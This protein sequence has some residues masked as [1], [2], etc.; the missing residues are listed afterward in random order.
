[1]ERNW[2]CMDTLYAENKKINELTQNSKINLSSKSVHLNTISSPYESNEKTS[3]KTVN[4]IFKH[5]FQK[6]L[7][8]LGFTD[9]HDNANIRLRRA[10]KLL[11]KCNRTLIRAENEKELLND[12]CRLTVEA[13]GYRMAWVGF[14]ERN[15]M[16]TVKPVAEFGHKKGFLENLN[17]SWD[18]SVRGQGPVGNAIRIG[19]SVVNQD[20]LHNPKFKPWRKA[21]LQCGYQSSIGLPLIVNKQV[22][23]A[24]VLYAAEP[25]AFNRKEVSL[26][27]DLANDLAFGIQTLRM[28]DEHI[29]TEKKLEFLAYHDPLTGLPN[30]RLLSDRF[31]QITARADRTKTS[32]AILYLDLDNFK[33]VNDSFGHKC[34]DQF[35]ICVAERLKNSIRKTDTLSRQGGDEFVIILN[36]ISTIDSIEKITKNIINSFEDPIQIDNHTLTTSFSIGISMYPNDGCEFD[37]LLN[38]ADTALSQSKE[39]GK[40]TYSFFCEQMNKDAVEYALM[41]EQLRR[42]I[43]NKEFQLYF[44]PQID[45]KSN[46]IIGAEALVRWQHPSYGLMAPGRFI[47]AAEQSGLI[48]QIGEIVL[49]EAC[50][51]GAIWHSEGMHDLVIAVN[52]SAMQFKKGNLIETV[53]SAL[54]YSGF[55][56]TSLELELTESVMLHDI[57]VVKETLIKL[58]EIGVRISIDDFGTGYSNLSYLKQL[59]IDKLKIDQTFIRDIIENTEDSAIVKAIIQ[60][61]HTLEL[62][63]IAE[64]VEKKEH[65]ALLKSYGVDEIQGFLF[66]HPLSSIDFYKFY[67]NH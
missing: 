8:K 46:N 3:M 11:S 35:L 43:R 27:E 37:I 55:P 25:Y 12:I 30:R 56:S 22:I 63:V 60:L 57:D 49:N 26:L 48:V 13:G 40:S 53:S 61:G 34:G 47:P 45:M 62:S 19:V 58:K 50:K 4:L 20:A 39:A 38:H 9:N 6:G 21:A 18:N 14:A 36:D 5:I 54:E 67:K 29:S 15:A 28:R 41:Q 52:L 33:H 7:S 16:K 65:F 31:T 64:G 24:L 44:Q 17:I 42:A 59:D 10:H 51:Q 32:I 23:G 66:S 1:M 2:F